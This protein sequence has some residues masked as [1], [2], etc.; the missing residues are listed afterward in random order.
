[1]APF[2]LLLFIII[3]NLIIMKRLAIAVFLNEKLIDI[4]QVCTSKMIQVRDGNAFRANTIEEEKKCA[5]AAACF[6]RKDDL[7]AKHGFEEFS[8]KGTT[9]DV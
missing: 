1:V 8:V 3:F 5:I 6:F 4:V 2:I 9:I 7:L